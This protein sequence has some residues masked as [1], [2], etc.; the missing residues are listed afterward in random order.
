MQWRITL[1]FLGLACLAAARLEGVRYLRWT[2]VQPLPPDVPA[3]DS[4]QWDAWVRLH[5]Y[6]IRAGIDHGIEDSISTL[7]MIGTSF[8]TLP[9]LT[10]PADAVTP[11]GDL[12]PPAR[13]RM[14]AFIEG[15]DRLDDERFRSILQF[16][17]RQQISQEELRPYLSGNLRRAA[18][19]RARNEHS[20]NTS[21]GPSLIE[22]I[23]RGLM[24]A[25]KAPAR[26]RRIGV[27]GPGLDPEYDPDTFN[28]F[29]SLEGA[30][31]SGLAKAG[32]VEVVLYDI[33]PWV[34]S[35]VRSIASKTGARF[36]AK[37]R[38]DDLDVVAQTVE[39]GSDKGFDLMVL[40]TALA[41][42]SPL[43]QTLVMANVAQMMA[44]GGVFLTSG[45]ASGTVP[46]TFET[47]T[48]TTEGIT[49]YRRR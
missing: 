7:I 15:L 25:G 30:L 4:K 5:D 8:T 49:V 33:N 37:I 27:I 6:E 31:S 40:S 39:T 18:L 13:L 47:L 10:G 32:S 16:L 12:T 35:H 2:E 28:L 29:G 19:E 43:E 26:I 34:L 11:A 36:N 20:R 9:R 3:T 38:A 24:S 48:G 46:P 21:I 23:L 45:A 22:Q 42:D 44:S 17:R 14:N 1:V 41:G